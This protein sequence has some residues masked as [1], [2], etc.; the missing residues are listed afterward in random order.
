[1]I[2]PSPRQISASRRAQGPCWPICNAQPI[3][4]QHLRQ[5]NHQGKILLLLYFFR[6][7]LGLIRP[8]RARKGGV[9]RGAR[10]RTKRAG[11]GGGGGKARGR[12]RHPRVLEGG[13]GAG[14]LRKSNDTTHRSIHEA[15][16]GRPHVEATDAGGVAASVSQLDQHRLF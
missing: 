13:G 4:P 9:C 3:A 1:M 12:W 7:S 16:A 11:G 10:A 14:D 15:S 8:M 2:P 5:N 6:Y